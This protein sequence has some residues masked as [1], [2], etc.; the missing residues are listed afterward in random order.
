M[1]AALMVLDSFAVAP[2]KGR[3]LLELTFLRFPS[4]QAEACTGT[5]RPEH[6]SARLSPTALAGAQRL[7]ACE[8]LEEKG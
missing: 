3:G 7:F 4:A 2:S 1:A 5:K 8:V 6:C